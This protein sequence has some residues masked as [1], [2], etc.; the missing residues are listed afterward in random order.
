M[1]YC[2]LRVTL[3]DS[4]IR[5]VCKPEELKKPPIYWKA[6]MSLSSGAIAISIANP[7]DV[8][9]VRMQ[10]DRNKGKPRYSG[11]L[12]AYSTIIKEEGV[13]TFWKGVD[14]NIYRNAI[15]NCA[16]LTGFF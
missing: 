4:L 10:A 15:I 1:V 13:L 7:T 14:V 8:V 9:K 12:A 16:E 11:T 3:Y 2:G 5:K 6:I